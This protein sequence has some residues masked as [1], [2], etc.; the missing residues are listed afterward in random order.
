MI[1][2]ERKPIPEILEMLEPYKRVLVL[3]CGG[4]VTVC[5][6]G[7]EKQAEELASQLRL[8]ATTT[9]QEKTVQFDSITRQ[10][11]REFIDNLTENPADYDAVLTIACGVGVQ[12]MQDLFPDVPWIPGLN[13]TF[14]GANT[15]DGIWEEYCHGCGDCVLGSTA[16]VCP[17]AKCSKSLLNGACGGTSDDGKCE[18]KSEMDCAWHVIFERL[19]AA[20]NL[21]ALKKIDSVKD[22]RKDRGAGVRRL[23]HAEMTAEE[24]EN[25]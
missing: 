22:W 11:D 5:L 19:K 14:Y 16:G 24:F 18:V 3:G 2:G 23:S 7:G 8:A 12:F 9:G 20:R 13:T 10:C 1:V 6:T 15:A 21:D 25:E 4:C 17:M